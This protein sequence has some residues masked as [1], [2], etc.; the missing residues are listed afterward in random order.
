MLTYT[1]FIAAFPEFST[2]AQALVELQIENA[3]NFVSTEKAIGDRL[4]NRDYAAYLITA[5]L[6]TI[7]KGISEGRPVQAI[8]NAAEGSVNIGFIPPPI[9][10]GFQ[11]WLAATPY[12][13]QLWALLSV[14]SVG[15]FMAGGYPARAGMRKTNGNF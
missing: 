9:E 8:F 3:L 1:G 11:F 12:G 7:G 6:L 13:Q 2:T 15:G 5:H 10:N 4:K 14:A